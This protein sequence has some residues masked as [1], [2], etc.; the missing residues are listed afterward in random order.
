MKIL[1][2]GSS[3]LIGRALVDHWLRA[4]HQI[5]RLVRG[6][7][8][9]NRPAVYWN[10]EGDYLDPLPLEG[11]D[12]VVHLAG[13][14]ISHKRW[15]HA[16]KQ[17]IYNSRV[18]GTRLLAQTLAS[19]SH[20]PRV[21]LSASAVGYYGDR[22]EEIVDESQSPGQGF[23]A[24]VARDWEEATTP[25]SRS[26]IRTV[27]VRFG[28]V[29]SSTG[30]IIP[31]LL[32]LFRWGLGATLG[33][34]KQYVSWVSLPDVIR[35]VDFVIAR[36]D[37]SG[38]VNVT[39]PEPITNR[40]MTKALARVVRRPAIAWV[41]AWMLRMVQGQLAEELLLTSIRAVP[42]RIQQLGFTFQDAE[43]EATVRRLLAAGL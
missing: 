14:N 12:V 37:L 1:V 36:E 42:R 22:G 2:S 43:F 4:G 21:F 20:K 18:L 16:Q 39:S 5:T 11:F 34:G 24:Q 8:S 9:A 41:P 15:T 38:P 23:L 33:S 17:R 19:L 35:A 13:E 31:P 40:E 25:A 29:L 3:G 10:P 32:R 26:G 27:P 6:G 7:P 28:V 30:G